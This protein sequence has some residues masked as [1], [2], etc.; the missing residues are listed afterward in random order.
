MEF[1]EKSKKINQCHTSLKQPI[2]AF[3]MPGRTH[4]LKSNA[5]E[6]WGSD[7]HRCVG[8]RGNDPGLFHQTLL[9]QVM[10]AEDL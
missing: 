5:G 2:S 6:L 8:R 10:E 9:E 1:Q 4:L 3:E 7:V